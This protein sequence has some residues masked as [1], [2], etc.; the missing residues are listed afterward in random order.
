MQCDRASASGTLTKRAMFARHSRE[1]TVLCEFR[2]D[3]PG[4]GPHDHVWANLVRT[5]PG[6]GE[7]MH[8][9]VGGQAHGRCA[10][11]ALLRRAPLQYT[12]R[13]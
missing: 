8:H 10:P 13:T 9:K 12:S 6:G 7:L 1:C 11:T 5:K 2:H 4:I 3:V